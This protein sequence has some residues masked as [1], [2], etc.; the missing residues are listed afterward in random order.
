MGGEGG[1]NEKGG[2]VKGGGGKEKGGGGRRKGGGGVRGV[3]WG[4]VEI[5][6]GVKRLGD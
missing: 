6:K 4:F 1:G 5:E 2:E 3:G